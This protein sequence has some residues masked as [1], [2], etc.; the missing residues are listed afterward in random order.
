MFPHKLHNC[1][2]LLLDLLSYEVFRERLS[3]E[4][5]AMLADHLA[6]C[7]DCRVKFVSFKQLIGEETTTCVQ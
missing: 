5:K 6:K 4:M 3:P 2:E 7:E 1:A